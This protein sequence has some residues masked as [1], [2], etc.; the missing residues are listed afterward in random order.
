MVGG[1]G[2]MGL[3]PLYTLSKDPHPFFELRN[4]DGVVASNPPSHQIRHYPTGQT[5]KIGR[6]KTGNQKE[7]TSL[8]SPQRAKNLMHCVKARSVKRSKM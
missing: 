4:G 3:P 8:S 7:S 6:K 5:L 1:L 2:V